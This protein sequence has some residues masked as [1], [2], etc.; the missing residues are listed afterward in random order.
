MQR[1]GIHRSLP[2]IGGEHGKGAGVAGLRND[3]IYEWMRALCERL[4]Y[5]RVCCGDWTRILGPTPTTGVGLTGVVLDPPYAADGRCE[6]VYACDD[7]NV[8]ADVRKW[9]L[10]HGEDPLLRV[11]LCGYAEEHDMPGW[12]RVA[13]K[14]KGGYG[15]QR[16]DGTNDNAHRETIWFSPHCLKGRQGDLFATFGSGVCGD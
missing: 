16:K 5:V 11:V 13:W 10:E 8:S 15:N 14:A 1:V 6:D 3:A 4:R 2:N 12:T 9:A 7:V